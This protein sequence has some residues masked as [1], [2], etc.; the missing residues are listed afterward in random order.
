MIYSQTLQ[1]LTEDEL[2]ILFLICQKFFE[3]L[4]IPATY[5]YVKMLK[6]DATLKI[7]DVLE[8]QATEENK[9]IFHSLKNKLN[10]Q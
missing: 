6:R 4:Q 10:Q 8:K 7:I 5:N 9:F 1:T 2:S 3:P